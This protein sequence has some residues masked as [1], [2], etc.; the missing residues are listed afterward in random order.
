MA[1][2][3]PA[4]LFVRLHS[5]ASFFCLQYMIEHTRT[6]KATRPT[7]RPT[8]PPGLS[9]ELPVFFFIVRLGTVG[10]T[11]TVSRAVIGVHVEDG[12]DDNVLVADDKVAKVVSDRDWSSYISLK[13]PLCLIT[14][15][16]KQ[17]RQ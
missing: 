3:S 17:T 5:S 8:A 4:D 16:S 9:P 11:V 2:P 10:V 7:A 14:R 15:R 1:P 13:S 6:T 12:Q